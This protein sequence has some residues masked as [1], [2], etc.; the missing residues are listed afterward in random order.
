MKDWYILYKND[1]E[2]NNGIKEYYNK[3]ICN[4]KKLINKIIKYKK[5]GKILEA[6]C[7]T[8]VLSVKLS[9][10]GYDVIA[11]D[12]DE[13]M[14]ELLNKI[15]KI[16]TKK[17]V[18]TK[19][20]DIFNLKDKFKEEKIDII[21]SVGVLEHFKDK[22]IINLI[23][24]QISISNYVFIAIPTKYFNKNEALYG[25]ERFLSYKKWRSLIKESGG[26]IIE[27][28]S[29][30]NQSFFGII[31]NIRKYFRPAPIRVFVVK[32]DRK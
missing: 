2:N 3:K 20:I 8:G 14:L 9:D 5:E 23:K 13:R 17:R 6:G 19:K 31:K 29:C 28:F 24:T 1:I 11:I 15:N 21:F 18:Q 4:R 10:I 25:N 30:Q 26:T 7:G 12:N 22:E 32:G 16:I 27:E